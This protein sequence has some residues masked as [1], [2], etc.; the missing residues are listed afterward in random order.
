MTWAKPAP[1]GRLFLIIAAQKALILP[2]CF[3]LTSLL[4]DSSYDFLLSLLLLLTFIQCF[5]ISPYFSPLSLGGQYDRYSHLWGA[6]G[7]EK[8]SCVP[9]IAYLKGNVCDFLFLPLALK[10]LYVSPRIWNMQCIWDHGLYSASSCPSHTPS[11]QTI[12]PCSGSQVIAFFL[13]GN[14]NQEAYPTIQDHQA[15]L[16]NL[17]LPITFKRLKIPANRVQIEHWWTHGVHENN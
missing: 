2:P 11:F 13:L 12:R 5:V 4:E 3:T 9:K 6:H 7:T 14:R 17:S 15:P 8:I 10:N 16:E 1:P